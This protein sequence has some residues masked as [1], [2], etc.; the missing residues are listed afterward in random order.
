MKD[1]EF[2][3]VVKRSSGEELTFAIVSGKVSKAFILQHK[4]QEP[5]AAVLQMVRRAVT[6]WVKQTDAGREAWEYSGGDL[7]IGDLMGH[8]DTDKELNK[9][10]EAAGFEELS[11][12]GSSSESVSDRWTY[13]TVLV[14]DPPEL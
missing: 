1:Q 9:L 3:F 8:I 10:L 4:A 14:E 12:E 6:A 11:I 13:D 7:N 2:E 5:D